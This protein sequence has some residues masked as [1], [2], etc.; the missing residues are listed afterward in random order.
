M[1]R[2]STGSLGEGD[3]TDDVPSAVDITGEDCISKVHC[4]QSSRVHHSNAGIS[5]SQGHTRNLSEETFGYSRVWTRLPSGQ[6]RSRY[7]IKKQK[8]L[9]RCWSNSVFSIWGTSI[10]SERPR[11]GGR[12]APHAGD[13][14]TVR[15]RETP[16]DALQAVN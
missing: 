4:S 9:P 1:N 7:A 12:W 13:L 16:D 5:T 2:A 15:H 14:P 3:I 8:P 6:K 10:H 11:Q